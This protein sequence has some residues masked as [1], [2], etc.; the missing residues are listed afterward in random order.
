[1]IRGVWYIPLRRVMALSTMPNQSIIKF[2]RHCAS[3]SKLIMDNLT[4]TTAD[5]SST[6][7]AV[8]SDRDNVRSTVGDT[9]NP[10]TTKYDIFD[11][12]IEEFSKI[13]S[14]KVS[15]LLSEQALALGT[16]MG[17]FSSCDS[18]DDELTEIGKSA[19]PKGKKKYQF[20]E[21]EDGMDDEWRRLEGVQNDLRNE[22]A[23]ATRL[24]AFMF[25]DEYDCR[26]K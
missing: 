15:E 23:L 9:G 12:Q 19:R 20:D 7:D 3:A 2:G 8:G 17:D 11:I 4:M 5:D 1:M 24:S 25:H 26:F 14:P 13:V 16:F 10:F 22:L 6:S 21:D 18:D